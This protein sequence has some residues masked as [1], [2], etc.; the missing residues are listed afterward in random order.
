MGFIKQGGGERQLVAEGSTPAVCV[1]FIDLGLQDGRFGLKPKVSIVFAVEETITSGEY[2]GRS[3]LL[4]ATCTNTSSEQGR[5]RPFLDDWAGERLSD[6][7]L[8]GLEPDDLIGRPAVITVEHNE[9]ADGRTFANIAEI[10]PFP[11]AEDDEPKWM[12]E[13]VERYERPEKVVLKAKEGKRREK[14]AASSDAGDEPEA[15]PA[16]ARGRKR[17]GRR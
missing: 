5:L 13:A 3:C 12:A 8:F 4:W 9:S 1:D 6:E 10:A 16:P 2:E 14:A 11:L 7:E 15:G 17:F